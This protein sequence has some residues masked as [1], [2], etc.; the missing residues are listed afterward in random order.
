VVDQPGKPSDALPRLAESKQRHRVFFCQ[1]S[2]A[3]LTGTDVEVRGMDGISWRDYSPREGLPGAL[4]LIREIVRRLPSS[5]LL[6]VELEVQ[7][8]GCIHPG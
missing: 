4:A 3:D 1:V 2:N 6:L 8:Q 5:P 7:L